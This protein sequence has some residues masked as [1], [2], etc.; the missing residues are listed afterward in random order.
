MSVLQNTVVGAY[1]AEATDAAAFVAAQTALERV[2]LAT[3]VD[4]PAGELTNKEL[5]LMEL[6]RALAGRPRLLLLDEPLAG[7][8]GAEIAEL[9]TVIRSLS[10]D[11]VTIVIIEHTVQAM[12]RLVDRLIVLDHGRV[13]ASGQAGEVTSDPSVIEAYLGKRWRAAHA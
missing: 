12:M 9:L 11:R 7:L 5:R 10:A 2:G 13:L 1:V 8:G 6:A 4:A 3:R